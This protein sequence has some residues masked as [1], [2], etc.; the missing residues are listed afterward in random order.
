MSSAVVAV[1]GSF[2]SPDIFFIIIFFVVALAANSVVY[3][4]TSYK[5]NK[6][7]LVI[8][9]FFLNKTVLFLFFTV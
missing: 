8:Y 7:S 2:V 1:V 9:L 4:F 3:Q 5:I 6:I